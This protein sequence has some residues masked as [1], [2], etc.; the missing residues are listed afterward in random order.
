[1]P[2]KLLSFS[3]FF[4]LWFRIDVK[5]FKTS[6]LLN[7]KRWGFAFKQHLMDHVVQSLADLNDFIE[8]AD[9]GLMTQ[10]QEGDY[11]ALIKVMEYLQVK[12]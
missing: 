9:T 1:M 10:A 4:K 12:T 5:P 11:D 6:L 8:R 3:S 7:I 2:D